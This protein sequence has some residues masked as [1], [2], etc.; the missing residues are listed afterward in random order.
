M[1]KERF[2]ALMN[3]FYNDIEIFVSQYKGYIEYFSS[4]SVL[5]IF[6][7]PANKYNHSQNA[8]E[9]A[10]KMFKNIKMFNRVNKVD[11]I[12]S[13]SVNTG[14]I[15]YSQMISNYGKVLVSLGNTIKN[16]CHFESVT[17]PHVLA[18]SEA[19]MKNLT[20][21]PEVN[22]MIHLKLKGQEEPT[23]VYLKSN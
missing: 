6:G 20:S 14:N 5:S 11:I 16:A 3:K 9:C 7:I 17:K 13:I 4:D 19:T 22:K 21:R 15:F 12:I 18:L 10:E 8:F 23:I 2:D 1:S